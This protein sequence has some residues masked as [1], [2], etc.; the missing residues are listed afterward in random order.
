MSETRHGK[1]IFIRPGEMLQ[2]GFWFEDKTIGEYVKIWRNG[3]KETGT[4][5]R[6]KDDQATVL[7]RLQFPHSY[8]G[9][10]YLDNGTYMVEH[11]DDF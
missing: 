6:Q 11:E 7:S 9:A 2:I 4:K 3:D 10:K 8:K 1:G 5:I